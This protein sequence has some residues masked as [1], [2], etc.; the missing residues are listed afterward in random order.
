MDADVRCLIHRVEVKSYHCADPKTE[1]VLQEI[2]KVV[3]VVSDRILIESGTYRSI[4]SS[5][6]AR[7]RE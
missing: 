6:K 1:A 7:V 2:I 3:G 4:E 5:P